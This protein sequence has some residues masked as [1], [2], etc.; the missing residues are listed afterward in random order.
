M[1]ESCVRETKLGTKNRFN[2][3][4]SGSFYHAKAIPRLH[5][6]ARTSQMQQ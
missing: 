2:P 4:E 5:I 3:R 6:Y 1:N